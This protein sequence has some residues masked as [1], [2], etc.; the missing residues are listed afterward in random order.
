M[1]PIA[2]T[3]A[4]YQ[5][6]SCVRRGISGYS[7][8]QVF[9]SFAKQFHACL[10]VGIWTS[11]LCVVCVCTT[12]TY[13]ASEQI[14]GW[15]GRPPLLRIISGKSVVRRASTSCIG[16]SPAVNKRKKVYSH[17][18]QSTVIAI[19]VLCVYLFGMVDYIVQ[20]DLPHDPKSGRRI[21]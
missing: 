5:T 20:L 15:R 13:S 2:S 1:A 4:W 12:H 6:C 9:L 18:L 19:R 17:G 8:I 21:S 16:V 10:C 3:L 14:V 11:V 7:V